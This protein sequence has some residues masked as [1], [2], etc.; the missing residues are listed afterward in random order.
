MYTKSMDWDA[1]C[2]V[3]NLEK[4]RHH[5]ELSSERDS[6]LLTTYWS[7]PTL[8]SRGLGGPASR[9]LEEARHHGELS[10][11]KERLLLIYDLFLLVTT[12]IRRVVTMYDVY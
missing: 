11:R 5:G 2:L 8:S 12:D 9:H 7:E 6:S 3:S 4:A 1:A 10:Q